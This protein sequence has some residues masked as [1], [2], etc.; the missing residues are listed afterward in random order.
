MSEVRKW[1]EEDK[2]PAFQGG[3]GD[4]RILM[5]LLS[6][7]IFDQDELI[8][9]RAVEA[10]GFAAGFVAETD[11]EYVRN[12]L[13]RL[14]WQLNDESGSIG[15]HAAETIG[16]ILLNTH[17]RFTEFIPLLISLLDMDEG[18]AQ[19]FQAGILWAIS[20][21]ASADPK[22]IHPARERVLTLLGDPSPEIR[23][24]AI[25]CLVR[26]GCE[27]EAES[28]QNLLRDE[29]VARIYRNRRLVDVRISQLAQ[30]LIKRPPAQPAAC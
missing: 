8:A 6:G 19:R 22:L 18:D 24:E 12:Q 11:L 20:R 30:D 4:N 7:L 23:A 3:A 27:V 9:W 16:T 17:P 29:A 15:W 21:V 14:F 26:M 10:Y 28:R 5:S 2:L 13:R 25:N 1:L